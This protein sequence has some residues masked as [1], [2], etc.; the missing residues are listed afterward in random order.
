VIAIHQPHRYSRV[1]SLFAEFASCFNEADTIFIAPIYSAGEDPIPGVTAEEMVSRIKSGGH[2]DVRFLATPDALAPY[3]AS[4]A[5]PGD[6]VI[7]L[8]AG[9]ITNWA[10]ALPKELAALGKKA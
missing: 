8:G 1:A 3:I 4:I 2:R 7:L 6:F 5:E 9:N 10:A